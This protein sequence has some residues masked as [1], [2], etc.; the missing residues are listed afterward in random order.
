[1]PPGMTRLATF[2][3]ACCSAGLNLPLAP[4]ARAPRRRPCTNSGCHACIGA[5]TGMAHLL[6]VARLPDPPRPEAPAD[7]WAKP[8]PSLARHTGA[9][10]ALI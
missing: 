2:E 6:E 8:S 1:M 7:P 4:G 3:C 5:C 10:A 9:T